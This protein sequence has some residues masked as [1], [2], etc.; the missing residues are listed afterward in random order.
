MLRNAYV[1]PTGTFTDNQKKE[2]QENGQVMEALIS[3]LSDI[4]FIDVQDKDNPKE[5]WDALENIYGGDEHVKQAKEESLRGKFEDMWMDEGETIQQYFIRIKTIV[6]DIK[7]AGGKID[8]STVVSKV[9]RSLL[10]VC[11]IRVA[12]IQELRSIEKTKVSLDSIIAKLTTYELNNYDGSIQKTKSTFRASAAPSRKGKEASTSCE[13]RQSREMDDEEILMEF[14]TLLAK[15]LP[16]GAGKYRGKLPLKCFSCNRIGH[17]VVN[18]PN[19]DNKDK[20]EKFKNFKGGN[21]RN[22][23]VAVDEGVTDE[24]SKDEESE[25]I[26]FVAVKEDVSDKKALVSCF[27]NSNEWII[28]SGCS[29]HMTGDRSKFLSLEEYDGGVVRF[30]NDAPCMVKG[31]GSISLSGKSSADN[32]YWVEG[33]RH[34]LLSVAQLNDNG[35]TLEFKDGVCKIKGKSVECKY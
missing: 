6:G 34:N 2:V 18:C 25:D 31:R 20:P 12:A 3:S 9:L 8:D 16:K 14:E 17:I 29:Y 13:P 35:L 23:F 27:D 32:V 30:G 33:L 15:R 22:Y 28:D 21:K 24:E 5:V 26:V 4:E 19:G 11:A 10:P 7:S 1:I